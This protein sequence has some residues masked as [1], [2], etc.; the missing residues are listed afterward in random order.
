MPTSHVLVALSSGDERP[1]QIGTE[2]TGEL[3]PLDQALPSGEPA[4]SWSFPAEA[5]D[6][7]IIE[8]MS[9]D[10]DPVVYLDGPGLFTP[11]RDDDGLGVPNSLIEYTVA[12]S[13]RMRVVVSSYSA[14]G[15]GAFRLRVIRRAR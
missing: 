4:Q 6:E 3:G 14:E 7:L 9:E 15:A 11:L 8:L 1:M 12:E 13:G 10:F 5:G 2:V